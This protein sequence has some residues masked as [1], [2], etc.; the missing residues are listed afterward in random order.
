[1][2][3][4]EEQADDVLRRSPIDEGPVARPDELFGPVSYDAGATVLHALRATIG[5]EAFF[6][7][8]RTWVIEH[9]NSTATTDQFMQHVEAVSGI[10]LDAFF[11]AWVNAEDRPDIYPSATAPD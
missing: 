10:D 7:S 11:A 8:L 4:L 6:E 1:M 5:D 9:R 3:P 2:S